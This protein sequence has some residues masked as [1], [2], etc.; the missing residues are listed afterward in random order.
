MLILRVVASMKKKGITL[1]DLIRRIVR[2]ENSGEINFRVEDKA[3]AMEAVKEYFTSVETPTAFMDFDGYRIEFPDWWLNIRASNTEPYLR[4]LCE[5][6]SDPL[7]QSKVAEVD[8][9]LKT[10]FGATR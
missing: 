5:A 2:Y 9:L 1:A 8:D 10:R 7:L 3:G 4:F 6:T